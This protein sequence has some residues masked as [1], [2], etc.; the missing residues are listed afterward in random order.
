[1]IVAVR[2]CLVLVTL[3]P[4]VVA[5]EPAWRTIRVP[6]TWGEQYEELENFDGSAWYRAKFELP[7]SWKGERV[8]LRVEQLA[9]AHE[10]YVNGTK[11][12]SAGS[13]PPSFTGGV[14]TPRRYLVEPKALRFG[15]PNVVA[16]RVYDGG[17]PGGFVGPA[18]A[19]VGE[20]KGIWLS[21]TW[22]FRTGDDVAWAKVKPEVVG[23]VAKRRVQ[24]PAFKFRELAAAEDA[25][26]PPE[27]SVAMMQ[28][29]DDLVVECVLAEP[30]VRQP[31]QMHF[32]TRGR[33]WVVNYE[34]YPNP[35]GLKMLSRDQ[36]WRAVYD[37]TPLPPPRGVKGRDRI[38]VHEDTDGDGRFDKHSVFLDDLNIATACAVGE[39]GVWVLNPPYLLFYADE[40]GD[41]VPDGDPEVHLEGFGIEDTHSCANSLTWGPDGWLY[42]AQGSTVSGNVRRPGEKTGVFSM[43]QNVWRYHP[44]RK[45]YEVFAEGGGNAF[46]VEFDSEGRLF[47]GHNGGNTRGFHYIQGGYYQKGFGKHGPLSNP[48]AYGYFPAMRH[49]D[50]PRF[51]HDFVVYEDTALPE[52]YRGKLFGVE[53][54][55]G[56]LVLS[57]IEDDGSTFRTQDLS[58]VLKTDEKRFRPVAIEVG[59]DGAIYVADFHEPQISHREHFAGVVENTT[60]RIYRIRAKKGGAK[61]LPDLTRRT[62][63]ELVALLKSSDES[64]RSAARRVLWSKRRNTIDEFDAARL[65]G[66]AALERLWLAKQ[67]LAERTAELLGHRDPV[68]REWAVRLLC[69]IPE[70]GTR[71]ASR[72]A[73]IAEN[74]TDVRVRSQLA[75]SARRIDP[76]KNRWSGTYESSGHPVVWALLGRDADADDPHLPLMIWWAIERE[77]SERPSYVVA[78]L[79]GERHA[80]RWKSRVLR[81]TVLTRLMR[82]LASEG[83]QRHLELCAR[84]LKASPDAAATKSLTAG[85][86]EAYR[87]RALVGL[88]S[89]LVEAL[90]ESGGASLSLRLRQRDDEAVGESLDAIVNDKVTAAERVRLIEILGEIREARAVDPLLSLLASKNDAVRSATLGALQ[91]FD[92][93][94]IGERIV[95]IVPRSAAVESDAES[96]RNDVRNLALEV[97]GGRAAWTSQLLDAVESGR[98]DAD[99]VPRSIVRRL[100]LHREPAVARRVEKV[101]GDVRGAT[102]DEMAAE[103]GRLTETIAAGSGDPFGGK[104]LYEKS[105]GKCHQLFGEGGR[106]GPDLTPYQ[107]KDT[108][109]LLVNVV[110]PS[111]EVRKGFESSVVVT[112]EGRVV[113]GFLTEQ[114]P[115]LVVV[116]TAEGREV[117]IPAESVEEITRQKASLM[118]ERLLD[119]LTDQQVRDLFAYLRSSQPLTR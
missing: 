73:H 14:E 22:E 47:S 74:E 51:T 6:G 49:H 118:P 72:L 53:P 78:A 102:S 62:N 69:D 71:Y 11:V 7:A 111:A 38:T 83:S 77:C 2:C 23:D 93:P 106:I 108:A 32:D 39:K 97:L 5:D 101:W 105:C 21:G 85:F 12:G 109:N 17:G 95:A 19:V 18:P 24:L 80:D 10:A 66:Q 114:T 110:N 107:R 9:G 87:G 48:H 117:R 119:G 104:R 58:R 82:R 13:F 67:G 88:P 61:P 35:A 81:E 45:V 40:N 75:A 43:G 33:L 79:E 65:Q 31:L 4:F 112:D 70:S 37:K 96:G 36:H 57:S 90:A 42:G 26:L 84:L 100:T 89:E 99:S 8:E 25:P 113:T 55:Q 16:F 94:R 41:D 3:S 103:I 91:A 92:E 29:P 86:E 44:T 34:Q 30:V 116:R 115:Q 20:K 15:E 28:V 59:P 68:V 1:M 54:L 63:E 27:K 76:P 60:G 52:P 46:G 56:Q 50:V 64:L 98:I